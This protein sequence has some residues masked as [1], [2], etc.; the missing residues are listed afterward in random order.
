MRPAFASSFWMT[1]CAF[2]RSSGSR[3][4]SSRFKPDHYLPSTKIT[5]REALLQRGIDPVAVAEKGAASYLQQLVLYGFF[6]L[7]PIPQLGGCR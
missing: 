1:R 6:M 4:A 3:P 5:D 2:R 7:I